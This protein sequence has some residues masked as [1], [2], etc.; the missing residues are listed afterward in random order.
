MSQHSFTYG[1]N[2]IRFVL[3]QKPRKSFKISVMPDL[4]VGVSAPQNVS[5]EKVLLRVQKKAPWIV[6]QIEYFKS[7]MPKI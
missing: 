4:S 7:F 3:E 5:V 1:Q 2:T 6:R